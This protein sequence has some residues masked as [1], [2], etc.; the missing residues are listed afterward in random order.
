MLK[1]VYKTKK[2]G[3][4]MGK[5]LNEKMQ[6]IVDTCVER[7]QE[8]IPQSQKIIEVYDDFARNIERHRQALIEIYTKLDK[9]HSM[10]MQGEYADYYTKHLGPAQTAVAS[11]WFSISDEYGKLPNAK[12]KEFE[13]ILPDREGLITTM[14]SNSKGLR[15]IIDE[16]VSINSF[17]NRLDGMD[18][19]SDELNALSEEAWV[20]PVD[21]VRSEIMN[22]KAFI[23]PIWLHGTQQV[24][25]Y[26]VEL[27]LKFMPMFNS[28]LL[29]E[30][31]AKK[32][33]SILRKINCN[34][35]FAELK[36]DKPY[37]Q[38]VVKGTDN[39]VKVDEHASIGSN[40]AIG[41]NARV[42]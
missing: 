15:D 35:P 19:L 42:E 24:N 13:T 39:S 34:L 33:L 17:I 1:F 9:A 18:K 11:E 32:V 2:D 5:E 29:H 31:K 37:I 12:K 38:N 27:Y 36:E 21:V 28:I 7:N 14:N 41:D 8:L 30:A 4:Y 3:G 40:N 6:K 20:Y 22:N 23:Q 16:V 26:H 10:L 25:P